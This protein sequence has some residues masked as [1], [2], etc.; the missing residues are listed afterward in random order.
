MP[1]KPNVGGDHYNDPFPS[2]LRELMESKGV[3]QE[4]LTSVLGV[5][6]RQSVTG[7]IDGGTVPTGDKILA[8]ARYFH[9]SCDYL[10]GLTN[11]TAPDT[12]LQAVCDYTGLSE[13]AVN[14]LHK[15]AQKTRKR[16]RGDRT[17]GLDED[18]VRSVDLMITKQPKLFGMISDYIYNR[19]DS[20][21]L[22]HGES[23]K[24]YPVV[25]MKSDGDAEH[26]TT[27]AVLPEDV[28][29]LTLL[30]I[31]KFLKEYRQA[32]TDGEIERPMPI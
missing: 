6:S 13:Q 10:L 22:P 25:L 4:D 32:V 7:Y 19:Y 20:F 28:Q 24:T 30:N 11:V 12:E 9:V 23:P 26:S 17:I 8:L 1:R 18:W 29:E 3:R 14:N 5:K 2:R 15:E 16:R 31:M 21:I 27:I